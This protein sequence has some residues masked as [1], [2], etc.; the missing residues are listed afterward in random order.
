MTVAPPSL[1]SSLREAI[2]DIRAH[3]ARIRLRPAQVPPAS[4]WTKCLMMAGRGFGK[5]LA[6]SCWL[7]AE[8]RAGVRRVALVAATAADARDVLVE[9]E[10]G[11][12]AVSA[13]HERP[14]YEPSK[15]RLTWPSG[16]VGTLYSAEEPDRLRGPQHERAI[17][18]EVASWQD[19]HK[20]DAL[21][22]TWNNL[23]LGLRL[24]AHPRV[25]AAT[26]P[27]NNKLIRELVKDDAVAVLRG[28]TYDN[29]ANLAPA[30]RDEILSAYEGTRIGKQELYG[31]L[32]TDVPGAL[33]RPEQFDDIRVGEPPAMVRVV[34]AVDPSGGSEDGHDEQ[35]IIVSGKG[36]DG[37]GY[38]L[39]DVSCRET[40]D[41]WGRRVVGAYLDHEA[42]RVLWES[43]FGGDMALAVIK[44]AARDMGTV[45]ATEK[46]V[47]SRG[48]ILRAEPVAA[49]YEQGRVRHVG[50]FAKLEDQMTGY[51][52]DTAT[53]SPDRLDALVMAL[54][55]LMG[56]PQRG[57]AYGLVETN[58]ELGSPAGLASLDR[59]PAP[60]WTSQRYGS[61]TDRTASSQRPVREP[62]KAHLPAS[63]RTQPGR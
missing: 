2:E 44:T 59:L 33:W 26:T 41:G 53:K 16:A 34:V 42:D 29:L 22:T 48:K 3:E 24:G 47:A 7:A 19:A 63:Q 25:L 62:R 57:D 45:V 9:G 50:T 21:N 13:K 39:A 14:L 55:E 23:M 27:R 6:M 51:S 56:T 40:P 37:L 12:L 52:P 30:F 4:P 17:C 36:T 5:T 54:A 11:I 20:G 10:T 35:G 31:E 15:R 49:L 8:V 43:N 46:V 1:A 60:G 58:R 61:P 28:S 18:D 32:L 38:V